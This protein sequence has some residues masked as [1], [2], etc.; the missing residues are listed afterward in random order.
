MAQVLIV[1]I[2]FACQLYTYCWFGT[3][4]T[5]QVSIKMLSQGIEITKLLPVYRDLFP[6]NLVLLNLVFP[7][8]LCSKMPGVSS[9][10]RI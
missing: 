9:V 2:A 8:P 10:L 7:L 4:L 5:Q 6:T 1:Y 3:E